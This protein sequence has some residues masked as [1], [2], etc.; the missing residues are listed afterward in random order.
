[1]GISFELDQWGKIKETYGLSWDKKLER[2]IIPVI[3]R[4]KDPGRPEPK[5]PL[6]TQQNCN[7]LTIPAAALIDRIDYELSKYVFMG[8]AFPFFNLDCFGPGIV[9]AFLGAKLDNSTGRVWFFAQEELPISEI[10]LEYD[11]DNVWLCRIEDLCR[12][13]IKRWQGQVLFGMPDLGG[14]FDLLGVFRPAEK[15]FLDLYD[16]PDEVKRLTWELHEL[17]HRFYKEIND[18]LMPVNPGYTDWSAI[19]RDKPGYILQADISYM[20]SPDMFNEFVK[21]EIEATCKR[22]DKVFY[23]LDGVGQLA[24]LDLLLEIEGLGGV[25]WIPG[26]GKPAQDEW[27]EVQRKII[28]SG[29]NIHMT[30]D[31]KKLE[32]VAGQVGGTKGIILSPVWGDINEETEMAKKLFK[33]GIE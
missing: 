8:D 17:W 24:H 33:Y 13:A 27:P 20:I 10:H 32:R 30:G 15:L 2:P 16:E 19:Y 5:S 21:P 31:F 25:Q 28:D 26:E 29:R 4:G 18:I 12:E 11:A 9:S 14:A 1:M 6:L 7:D 22:L 3:L 23:H